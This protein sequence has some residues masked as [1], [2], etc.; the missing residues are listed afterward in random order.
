MIEKSEYLNYQNILM[1]VVQ[2]IRL[3]CGYNIP[4]EK[5]YEG[6]FPEQTSVVPDALLVLPLKR[7]CSLSRTET[8]IPDPKL[9]CI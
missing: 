7:L 2:L 6:V 3:Y 4:K 8:V 5:G 1:K 9:R